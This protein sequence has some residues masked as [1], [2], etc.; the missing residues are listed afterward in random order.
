MMRS[1]MVFQNDRCS[2]LEEENCDPASQA[3]TLLGNPHWG[4][5]ASQQFST[6]LATHTDIHR[7]LSLME[8]L[9]LIIDLDR[10]Q[11]KVIPTDIQ[12]DW[13]QL[14]IQEFSTDG[15][16]DLMM[17]AIATQT[18]QSIQYQLT[19]ANQRTRSFQ[20]Q[21]YPYA[22]NTVLWVATPHISLS[23]PE[24]IPSLLAE[25]TL[26]IRQSLDL[27]KIL[28]VTTTEICSLLQ[29]DRALI[30]QLQKDGSALV[31][32]E[33]VI[34]GWIPL[35]G[36][37]IYDPCFQA[38]ESYYLQGR[39]GQLN[40]I[41]DLNTDSCYREFLTYFQVQSNLVIPLISQEELW[42]FLIVHQCSH[43]RQW[44]SWEI[45]FLQ[46]LGN[47][48]GIAIAQSAILKQMR[49]VAQKLAFHFEN[50]PLAVI[51]WNQEFR[52]RQWSPQAEHILGWSF[53]EVEGKHWSQFPFIF[54]PDLE[55]F[56]ES[57][58][59]L[60]DGTQ[61]RQICS[62]RNLN[63]AG[64]LIYCEWYH[65]VLR[66]QEGNVLSILSLVQDVSDRH[67]AETALRQS[68]AHFRITFEQSPIGMSLNNL[69]G[70]IVQLNQAY[71]NLLGYR[72][73]ELKDLP[74]RYF[75]HPDDLHID[76]DLYQQLVNHNI[77]HYTIEKRLIDKRKQI[78]YT[79]FKVALI[80][81]RDGHPLHIISQVI[82]IS[83]R[84]QVE[85]SLQQSE[86]R[87]QL[88]IQ[89]N[90][91]GI[92]D[93][94]VQTNEVFFS[95]RWKEML[96]YSHEELSNTIEEWTKR[97]HP[98]DLPW[99]MRAIRKHFNQETP[100][101][102]NEHRLRCKD[103]SYKWILDRGQALW[104]DG[105]NVLRMVGS[106]TDISDRKQAEAA[107]RE[108]EARYSSLTND[109]LDKSAV[110]IFI[111]DAEFKV[112]WVNQ[113]LEKF[114][115]VKREE[116]IGR[117]KRSLIRDRIQY[118]FADPQQFHDTVLATYDHN[119]YTEHFECHILPAQTRQDRWL[120][121]LSQPIQ[122][123]LYAGGRIEH[124]TDISDRILHEAE[125]HR[126]NRALHTLSHCNQA[127]VRSTSEIDLLHNICDILVNL[128]GY[129]LA[130]IGYVEQDPQKSITPIAKAGYENGYLER[131]HLT[132]ADTELGRGPTGIAARRGQPCAFQDILTHP[133]YAPWRR[134]AEQRGYRSSIALPLKTDQGVFAVL[135][136]YSSQ[137]DAF[138]DS[139]IRLL[140]ELSAD[141]TYGVMALRT[142]H[143]HAESEEKFRQLAENIEDVFW[144][145]TANQDQ[146]LYVSPAYE[147]I[148]GRTQ[149]SLYQQP[150][151]FIE[152]I[153]PSD[154]PRVTTVL[155][156]SNTF[157]LEYRIRQPDGD[158]RWIWDRGFPIVDANGDVYRRA[159]IA[160]DITTR[161]QTEELLRRT[162]EHLE[163]RVAQRTA[164][165]ASA[166]LRLREELEQRQRTESH[167]EEAERRW[168]TLL[169]NVRL[170]VVG[171]DRQGTI[172]Y[173][174][175]FFVE[176]TGYPASEIL[177]K[178]WFDTLIPAHAC[179]K[180]RRTLQGLLTPEGNPHYHHT[181]LTQSGEEKMIAWNS[182]QLHDA[183][184]EAIGTMSI[185]EDITERYAIER[186]K[187]E[188]I[189]VVSHEL[190]T[191]L[192]SIHG[193]LNLLSS[194]LVDP[195]SSRGKHVIN[196][197]A[198]SA[199]RLVRL[200]NDI[201]ELERLESGK[202]RLQKQAIA[203]NDLLLLAVEQ[204][205]VMAT[206]A[207]V[208]LV[209]SEQTSG[210][211]FY[212]DVD[213][214][215]QVLTNLLSNAIKFS[216]PGSQVSLTVTQDFL[217]IHGPYCPCP[218][219]PHLTFTI[220][221]WGRGIPKDKLES[222]FERFHQVDASDSRRK[223]GTGL[224]LA[225]CRSIVEQHGGR[226]WVESQLNQGSQFS[227]SLP[228]HIQGEG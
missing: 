70:T 67:Q 120:E 187:D 96:G 3:S 175:P 18:P 52:I 6:E 27:D 174:N 127:I 94:N 137:P 139:E 191:P 71:L 220:E 109:V 142:H 49:L 17:E 123:G 130:W 74:T 47:Q 24:S 103:G 210:V 78:V 149:E 180:V 92:W 79:L 122:S 150:K 155:Q 12:A 50:S 162:N 35:L 228:I 9:M 56:K 129:R 1:D 90:H 113:T 57:V 148:W 38:Y 144:M 63:Q 223:G 36:H 143:A 154:R 125:L 41:E 68:E 115:G 55:E 171:L 201:L 160:K 128:G 97:V 186:M 118:L 192:T 69:D 147:K 75:I 207:G 93:W 168:R 165:L 185:G 2:S 51:E 66:D 42:G 204:M 15:F 158:L 117:D 100:F 34:P 13:V 65:S 156:S 209:V 153:H 102:I 59:S 114:F 169:E 73:E 106:H 54:E 124:Y 105:G 84:K 98:D 176:L 88:A 197:A 116:I 163:I 22:E 136:L 131:L 215:L 206:R 104:D 205:Q 85:E 45:D 134:Q 225:I 81:D 184:G 145:T 199:E 31:I 172:E 138:D 8:H 7:A 39:V 135:N 217:S 46:Q 133:N 152:S 166:N 183:Q 177:G 112:V 221:D 219:S 218:D 208:T 33:S 188:F 44:K 157:D 21:I 5:R 58:F 173:V 170:L 164:E 111:L 151:S 216:D 40:R 19:H 193:G 159:G 77:D 53:A 108:S 110:G 11:I 161:K 64:N 121:H 76:R 132:W 214:M 178:N 140:S 86:E 190:R 62:Y 16:W 211:E 126:L 189:S 26:K 4:D 146:M 25:I 196:I 195:S 30:L 80:Y 202:I 107:L 181:V 213:R 91:D 32:E 222:I 20:A 48:V 28:R 203:V 60:I 95:P 167:L 198:D 194:G 179:P 10:H 119:T 87:W 72:F 101:Y 212:A 141:I 200:V 23:P 37:K 14:T 61:D 82:D 43:S 182:T 29:T 99:A 89:G 226:I 224:G 227:F 83:D